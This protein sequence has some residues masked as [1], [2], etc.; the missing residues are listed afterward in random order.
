MSNDLR[1]TL[2]AK[3]GSEQAANEFMESAV[4]ALEKSADFASFMNNAADPTKIS[5]GIAKGIGDQLTRGGAAI[6]GSTI[7]LFTGAIGKEMQRT[8]FLASVAKAI[9]LNRV[10][11]AADKQKVLSYAG[12]VFKFAPSVACDPNMLASILSSAIHGEGGID[13][14]T[15]KMLVEME[16]KHAQT[17]SGFGRH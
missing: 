12:T 4:E 15:I 11:Q 5:D 16:N 8:R 7:G 17:I 2:V 6:V 14:M 10:L 9:Q 13:P 1:A 3:Y